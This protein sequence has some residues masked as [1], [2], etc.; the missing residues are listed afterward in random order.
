[1]IKSNDYPFGWDDGDELTEPCYWAE[2][3][4]DSYKDDPI[5]WDVVPYYSVD[6]YADYEILKKVCETCTGYRLDCFW[7]SLDELLGR[8]WQADTGVVGWP[9]KLSLMKYYRG[10]DYLH[11]AWLAENDALDT[12]PAA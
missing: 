3:Q 5:Y 1:M 7:L 8:R 6:I 4:D 11:A 12:P 9:E 2:D 10:G